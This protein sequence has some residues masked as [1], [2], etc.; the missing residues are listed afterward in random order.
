MVCNCFT[1][2]LR[3]TYSFSA[4]HFA[5]VDCIFDI[6]AIRATPFP[7]STIPVVNL[8]G[9]SAVGPS[10]P[11]LES[12]KNSRVRDAYFDG[13]SAPREWCRPNRL[14]VENAIYRC[15]INSRGVVCSHLT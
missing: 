5:T 1:S 10:P 12:T 11:K 8:I 6:Q 3:A 2:S 4:V 15:E 9:C 7:R 13:N 14:Y